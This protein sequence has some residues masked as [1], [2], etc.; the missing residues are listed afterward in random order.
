ME[1]VIT[2]FVLADGVFAKIMVNDGSGTELYALRT[3]D[4]EH[5][6]DMTY[7]LITG[8]QPSTPSITNND[9]K[10]SSSQKTRFIN[11]LINFLTQQYQNKSFVQLVIAAPE[12]IIN[13]IR[14]KLPE[15]INNV[16][17][18]ELAEDLLPKPHH[19]ISISLNKILKSISS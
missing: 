3:G 12:K 1:K 16:I 8:K 11:V 9:T 15:H 4:F 19:Q 7:E 14:Q 2:W 13:D 17:V 18:G 6:S 10:K 5:T